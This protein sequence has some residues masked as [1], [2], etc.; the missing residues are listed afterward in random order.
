MRI[1]VTG[2]SGF[3]GKN[4]TEYLLARG[5]DVIAQHIGVRP[6]CGKTTHASYSE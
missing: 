1:L 5:Y 2:G 3:V 6:Q 4:V